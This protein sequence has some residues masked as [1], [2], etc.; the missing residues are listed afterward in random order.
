VR[1]VG[2]EP[3]SNNDNGA[4][5]PRWADYE[6]FEVDVD[7]IVDVDETICHWEGF[8]QPRN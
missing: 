4:E 2:A 7:D 1:K 8:W 6:D 5:R 3:K